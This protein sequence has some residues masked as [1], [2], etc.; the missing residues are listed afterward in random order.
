MNKQITIIATAFLF[1]LALLSGVMA[2]SDT[3][4][5]D[6]YKIDY[7]YSG[8]EEGDTFTLTVTV[9]NE[10]NIEKKNIVIELDE[11]DPFDISYK[12]WDVGNLSANSSATGTFRVEVD[13]DTKQRTYDLGFEIADS[14]DDFDDEF[15]IEIDSDKADF[16]LG[17]IS[18]SPDTITPDADDV[19]IEITLEN[20]GGGDA[21]SVKATLELPSGMTHSGSFTKDVSLGT[22]EADDNKV[23]TFYIDVDKSITTGNK[24]A[25][26]IIEYRDDND[27]EKEELTFDISVKGIPLFNVVSTTLNP[28]KISGGES[29]QIKID[30]QNIGEEKGE[31]TSVRIFENSDHSLNFDEQTNFVGSLNQG[32]TGTAIFN[33]D[34]D[35]DA[36]ENTYLVKIQVRTLENGDVFTS[37]YT[38][39]VKIY[40][41]E[42]PNYLLYVVIALPLILLGILIYLVYKKK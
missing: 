2:I 16:I 18:S 30:I 11:D 22:I 24:Q 12:T 26:L 40:A 5:V 35:S 7:S 21:S 37:E 10:D 20:I 3:M 42:Q 38:V 8:A 15:E 34:V 9:T 25:T 31:D 1:S 27:D 32:E 23:A 29:G 14:K 41:K 39:P 28:S 19:K 4:Y 6:D 36:T 33:F 17:D 13:D